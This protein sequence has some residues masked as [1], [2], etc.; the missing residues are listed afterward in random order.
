MVSGVEWLGLELHLGVG[1]ILLFM[2]T[3]EYH[4]NHSFSCVSISNN[5]LVG[6][7][8]WPEA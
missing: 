3:S 7:F 4:Q 2:N 8:V 1:C 6:E 5:S